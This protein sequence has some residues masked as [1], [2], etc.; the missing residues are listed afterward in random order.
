MKTN[1]TSGFL[2]GTYTIQR[3]SHENKAFVPHLADKLILISKVRGFD[4]SVE[5]KTSYFIV[6]QAL[7]SSKTLA[8]FKKTT[9][10]IRETLLWFEFRGVPKA[11]ERPHT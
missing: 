7:C 8:R 3:F 9:F 6:S 5:V 11:L 2:M 1:K 4:V 10:S